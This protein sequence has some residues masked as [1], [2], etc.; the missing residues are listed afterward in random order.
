MG[1][2]VLGTFLF[3]FGP[4]GLFSPDQSL[5]Q[6]PGP[7]G[8]HSLLGEQ[9]ALLTLLVPPNSEHWVDLSNS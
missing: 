8:H 7:A 9:A 2:R 5:R 4:C 1:G 3:C 6:R